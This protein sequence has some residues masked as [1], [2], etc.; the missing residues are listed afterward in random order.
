MSW[1]MYDPDEWESVTRST[2]CLACQEIHGRRQCTGRC[3][4]SFSIGMQRRDPAEVR[5]IKADRQK[6]QED[7]IL[8]RAE[9]LKARR[10]LFA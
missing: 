7:E 4:G 2:P 6:R 1:I 8:R 3:T 10:R 9:A 5:R